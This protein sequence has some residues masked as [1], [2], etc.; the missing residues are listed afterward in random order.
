[1][2]IGQTPQLKASMFGRMPVGGPKPQGG[3]QPA[4]KGSGPK[5][6]ALEARIGIQAPAAVIWE[7]IYDLDR[8]SQWNPLYPQA[9]GAIRIGEKLKLTVAIPG[10]PPRDIEPVVLEWV[11]DEQL[12]WKLSML[13]GFIRSTRFVEIEALA[14]ASC[15]VANGEIFAGLM[16]TSLAR[17][18]G[19]KITR[20]FREMNEA[21]KGRAEAL[22]QA[23]QG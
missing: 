5:G 14:E 12:H 16:G 1:M 10:E 2:P 22:W 4:P 8:W 15:I 6:V 23:R 7:V 13:G 9:A 11:P 20:G 19:G 21:L 18:L 3:G 17:R